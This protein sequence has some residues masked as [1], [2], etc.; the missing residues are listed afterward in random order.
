MNASLSLKSFIQERIREL[1]K[2]AQK[3]D[4][5]DIYI[6]KQNEQI[7]QLTAI[8]NSIPNSDSYGIGLL[9]EKKFELMQQLDP[10][11]SG[12]ITEIRIK[13][14]GALCHLPLNLYQHG[15]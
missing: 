13:P 10:N 5:K 1:E 8:Y 15:I 4:A 14:D 3:P 12:L 11:F 6:A 2:Y 7:K 9:I